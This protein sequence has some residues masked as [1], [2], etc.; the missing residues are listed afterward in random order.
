MD[1]PEYMFDINDD[2]QYE[3]GEILTELGFGRFDY[4]GLKKYANITPAVLVKKGNE[5]FVYPGGK[6]V[7]LKKEKDVEN[8]KLSSSLSAVFSGFPK[9]GKKLVENILENSE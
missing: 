5:Y 8:I 9:S 1:T 6:K 7:M 3:E 4:M 2:V